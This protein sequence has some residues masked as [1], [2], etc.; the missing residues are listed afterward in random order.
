MALLPM[1]IRWS[2]KSQD[3]R[4]DHNP[5]GA[6]YV[7]DIA[8]N[9]AP[10]RPNGKKGQRMDIHEIFD[11]NGD[12]DADLPEP[13]AEMRYHGDDGPW[14]EQMVRGI[15]CNPIYAGIGPFPGL[16]DDKAWVRSAAKTI[17]QEGKEQFLVNLLHLLRQSFEN[18]QIDFD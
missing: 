2:V 6:E 9:D 8:A 5:N 10:A 15:L 13:N 16:I 18:A 4:V 14:S 12:S 17:D 1:P 11:S 7:P 3:S